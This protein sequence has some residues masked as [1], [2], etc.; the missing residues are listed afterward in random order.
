MRRLYF[1]L[2]MFMIFN[3]V[4]FPQQDKVVAKIGN[5][6]ITLDEFRKRYQL[7]PQYERSGQYTEEA[8][9]MKFMY[10]I[11]AEKLW[12]LE[13][14][15][16]GMDTSS[17]MQNTFKALE[18]MHVRDGLFRSEIESKVSYN[19]NDLMTG[20]QRMRTDLKLLFLFSFDEDEINSL[21]SKLAGGAK[22]DSLLATRSEVQFQEEPLIIE[23]GKL[24]E[25]IENML[26]SLKQGEF[27]KPVKETEGWLIYFVKERVD[28][29]I[30]ADEQQKLLSKVKTTIKTRR[31]DAEYQKFYRSFFSGKRVETDGLIFWSLVEKVR[32]ILQTKKDSG[33]VLKNNEAK[34]RPDDLLAIEKEFGPDTLAM[35]FIKFPDQPLTLKEFLAYFFFEGFFSDQVTTEI[36]AAKLNARI[37]G[38]IEQELI[39]REGM[40]RGIQNLPEVKE[41]IQR[42]RDNYLYQLMIQSLMD[43]VIVTDKEITEFYQKASEDTISSLRVNLLEI[44]TDSLEVVEKALNHITDE[45]SF[46][47]FASNH[48]KRLWTRGRGG[49][50]GLTPVSSLGE[51]GRIARDMNIGDVYGPVKLDEGYSI[52]RLIEKRDESLALNS[53]EEESAGLKES[54]TAQKYDNMLI[55][56]TV[57]LARKYGVTVDEQVLI[58]SG[59]K[60]LQMVVF[61]YMGFGGRITAVPLTPRF[62]EW[63]DPWR[64]K[65]KELP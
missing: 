18:K 28:K 27:S 13:A 11:I 25:D 34:L 17:L 40:K 12:A 2:L 55:D 35:P 50:L 41:D 30:T 45:K 62:I 49:E 51:L 59:I 53:L 19:E 52:I 46:R 54:L 29:Y 57:S 22:F 15:N 4:I 38:M 65:Q 33:L 43:S 61:R 9:I 31:T 6:T 3:A 26:Y 1:L 37:K 21:Y 44:L 10:S 8:A 63:V 36:I 24:D 20:L 23:F 7:T 42:W 14:E 58:N 39:A 56:K 47:E 16:L 32:N 60:N 5:Q 64:E 48:T